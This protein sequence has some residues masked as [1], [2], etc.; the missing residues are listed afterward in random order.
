[1]SA[2]GQPLTELTLLR[3]AT[4]EVESDRGLLFRTR[5]PVDVGTV[6]LAEERVEAESSG[7]GGLPVPLRNSE[8]AD[9]VD[10]PPVAVTAPK[11]GQELTLEFS[12]PERLA[13]RAA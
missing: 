1:H 5:D 2:R 10:A 8:Q 4:G 6:R 3:P 9:L 7:E 11:L 13:G 12:E